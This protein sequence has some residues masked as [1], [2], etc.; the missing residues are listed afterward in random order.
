MSAASACMLVS[1]SIVARAADA[2]SPPTMRAHPGGPLAPLFVQPR[3]AAEVVVLPFDLDAVPVTK[4][5]FRE[6]VHTHPRWRR[7]NASKL[8]TDAHYLED[9]RSDLEI[10]SA[11][12]ANQP[13][14]FV[15]YFA[16]AAYCESLGKRLPSESEW[17]WAASADATSESD[18]DIRARVLAFYSRPAGELPEVGMTPANEFGARDLHGVV[19]EWVADFNAS[20]AAH[21]GWQDGDEKRRRIC[22]GESITAEQVGEHA[23]FLRFSIRSELEARA[24]RHDLG[25]RC[26]RDPD[27]SRSALRGKAGSPAGHP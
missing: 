24:A 13:V 4:R 26:A 10:P 23:A 8:F 20:I 7:S 11:S 17:E 19:W 2:S 3:E 18:A 21:D 15:S 16:A 22:G 25:F 27:R 14:T 6:F 5:A 1:G 9:W 12:S